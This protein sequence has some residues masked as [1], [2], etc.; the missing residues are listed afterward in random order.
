MINFIYLVFLFDVVTLV[1]I[2][3]DLLKRKDI[4]K[5][6]P[7][8]YL[9]LIIALFL[10]YFIGQ[11][12]LTNEYMAAFLNSLTATRDVLVLKFNYS[13]IADAFKTYPIFALSYIITLLIAYYYALR[14]LVNLF[15]RRL[16]NKV[17]IYGMRRKPLVVIIGECPEGE[18]FFAQNGGNILLWSPTALSEKIPTYRAPLTK[19]G[20]AYLSQYKNVEFITFSCQKTSASLSQL[21]LQ[22]LT[23]DDY[24]N[25]NLFLTIVVNEEYSQV[26]DAIIEEGRG[27]IKVINKYE[28]LAQDVISRYPLSKYLDETFIN[29]QGLINPEKSIQV[30]FVGYGKVN[31]ALYV[32]TIMNSQ[33][34]TTAANKLVPLVPH[35]HLFDKCSAPCSKTLNHTLLRYDETKFTKADYL[36]LPD[37]V[38]DTTFHALDFNSKAFLDTCE[39]IILKPHTHTFVYVSVLDDLVNLDL[40]LKLKAHCRYLNANHVSFFVR[41]NDYE[42]AKNLLD[43]NQSLANITLYGSDSTYL[44]RGLL[45]DRHLDEAAANLALQYDLK[46]T[47]SKNPI[48]LKPRH[49]YRALS[50]YKQASNRYSV[51]NLNFKLNLLGFTIFNDAAPAV[52]PAA[53]TKIYQGADTNPAPDY[54]F[55]PP[56]NVRDI[57]AYQEHLRW[58]AF[59]I[60]N[61]YLPLKKADLTLTNNKDIDKRLHA[62]L[63]TFDGLKDY[64]TYLLSFANETT[65]LSFSDVD[66]IKYDYQILDNLLPNLVSLGE[67]LK[68][69]GF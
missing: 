69:K 45:F 44:K 60:A 43:T 32:H 13:L 10:V 24:T 19:S 9:L 5:T 42:T 39:Q 26:Y 67:V 65:P 6:N 41:V 4:T 34:V 36:P 62:C 40:V 7:L 48:P 47:H 54:N 8:I 64:H 12:V 3:R 27:L 20:F 66:V 35:Y 63:T 49:A 11:L 68:S 29:H 30:L 55:S 17:K 33:F 25:S 57:M 16:T 15:F 50:V 59:H 21:F 38:H 46:K 31:Q 53:F 28:L 56:F 18:A 51:L 1:M 37:K 52:D 14:L 23:E 22:S 58:N 61:G 2:G